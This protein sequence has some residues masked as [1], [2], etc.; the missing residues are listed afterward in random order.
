[1]RRLLQHRQSGQTIGLAAVAMIAVVGAVAFV[2]DLGFFLEG[3]R[4]LQLAADQA[5]M[6]GVIFL[7]ECSTQADGIGQTPN[8][9]AA[10][11]NANDMA[12]QFL[13]NNGPIARQLCGHP[14]TSAD[15]A[16]SSAI[17]SG[18][19]PGSDVT[20]GTYTPP[21]TSDLYY[22]LTVTIRC[23]PGF[24]FG[25][26]IMG[27]ATQPLSAS[28]T[29]VVGSNAST[30]CSAPID[31]VAYSTGTD[32]NQFG[33]PIGSG[34]LDTSTPSYPMTAHQDFGLDAGF[35]SATFAFDSGD[36]LEICLQVSNGNCNSQDYV[37]WLAGKVCLPLDIKSTP[38]LTAS[39][40]VSMGQLVTGNNS[41]MVQ[42][43]Y[44]SQGCPQTVCCPQPTSSV[45]FIPGGTPSPQDWHVKPGGANSLCL[46]QVAVVNYND[47]LTCG[48]SCNVRIAAFITIFIQDAVA[49][50]N[51]SYFEGV[52]VADTA[53]GRTGSFRI[54]GSKSTRL[55][56]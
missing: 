24:S 30:S 51:N 55:I 3:R 16:Q 28:A 48:G 43:G 40:G 2:I 32:A 56:R 37:N 26:I 17:N 15:F 7:P 34:N 22:T 19:T 25:R 4:E 8:P 31:V 33:Y 12:V 11:A 44:T 6:A 54:G 27:S 1:M 53:S 35:S 10:P 5:A 18:A 45:L 38:L 50:G 46:W 52:V 23:Q 41:G 36:I 47:A 13:N 20:P 21:G 29:A 39:P 49:N 42:R 9:C 14:T